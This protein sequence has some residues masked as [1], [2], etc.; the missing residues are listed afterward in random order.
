MGQGVKVQSVRQLLKSLINVV[1]LILSQPK[2]LKKWK[3][4]PLNKTPLKK[5]LQTKLLRGRATKVSKKEILD[6]SVR[7]AK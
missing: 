5:N 6:E 3:I 4:L 2:T 1:N 7:T